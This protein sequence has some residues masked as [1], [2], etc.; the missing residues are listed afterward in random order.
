MAGPGRRASCLATFL[1]PVPIMTK[2]QQGARSI[3]GVA[4]PGTTEGPAQ[5][6]GPSSRSRGRK[7]GDLPRAEYAVGRESRS[8]LFNYTRRTRSAP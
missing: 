2:V 5:H 6:A 7:G 3:Q 1:P 4:G 8:D